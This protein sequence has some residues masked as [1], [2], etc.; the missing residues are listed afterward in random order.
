MSRSIGSVGCTRRPAASSLK[1]LT[2]VLHASTARR[3]RGC[4]M[5]AWP[6]LGVAW[7]LGTCTAALG[8]HSA[9]PCIENPVGTNR[10]HRERRC[11]DDGRADGRA[12]GHAAGT[13]M[14]SIGQP[15]TKRKHG[16]A[17]R[18]KH[19]ALVQRNRCGLIPY[20]CRHTPHRPSR[21]CP[22]ARAR[23]RVDVYAAP[24]NVVERVSACEGTGSHVCRDWTGP[25]LCRDRLASPTLRARLKGG[26]EGRGDH[27][28]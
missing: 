26:R 22:S 28:T 5:R 4:G 19:T 1:R 7:T 9:S 15:S 25:H 6:T 17:H 13:R 24:A 8:T 16:W 3:M 27:C 2:A 18:D 23:A 12:G 14:Q 11:R 20:R 10:R 21:R